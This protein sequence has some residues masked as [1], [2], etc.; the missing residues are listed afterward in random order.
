M[1]AECHGFSITGKMNDIQ[2]TPLI[3]G[4]ENIKQETRIWGPWATIGFGLIIGMAFL[5]AQ[6]LVAIAFF[7]TKI[8][9]DPSNLLQITENLSSNGLLLELAVFASAVVGVGLIIV[10]I[11]LR[12]NASITEYLGLKRISKRSSFI[13][14]A[15]TI[16][17]V[18]LLYL[19]SF[20]PI[21]PQNDEFTVEAYKT[22][23][24]PVLFW[25][26][27]VIFAPAFEETFF[28]GFLFVGLKQS[29]IGSGG[30]IIVTALT[31]AM[32]HIQYDIYG[33]AFILILGIFLGIARLRTGSLWSPLM[34]HSFWNLI[35]TAFTALYA[36]GLIN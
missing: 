2:G 16:G 5:A 13:L 29:R 23:V 7:V 8:I 22:S 32:L 1:T 30:T 31:W 6:A 14:L 10:F 35:A 18:I 33:M 25:I 28:R 11:K 24:W 15:I 21:N 17:L 36:S 26:A 19:S 20:L 4:M 12:R 27:T 9:S 34:I 3:P